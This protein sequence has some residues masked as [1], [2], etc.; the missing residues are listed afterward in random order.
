MKRN[1]TVKGQLITIY[2][3]LIHRT[4]HYYLGKLKKKK[5][6]KKKKREKKKRKKKERKKEERKSNELSMSQPK[7]TDKL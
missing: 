1:K 2:C 4:G 3:L 5:K 7:I 6:K